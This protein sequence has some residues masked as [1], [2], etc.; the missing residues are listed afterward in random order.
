LRYIVYL[1]L[2]CAVI[3]FGIGMVELY[4][5]LVSQIGGGS[6]SSSVNVN[7]G[8]ISLVLG[9]YCLL[10]SHLIRKEMQRKAGS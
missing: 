5:L 7:K 1:L 8:A 9:G 3:F 2:A 4:P 6:D 10:R